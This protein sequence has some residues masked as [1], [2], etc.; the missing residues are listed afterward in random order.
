M[1]TAEETPQ[2]NGLIFKEL[3]KRGY[4]LEG[5][6]R[7]WN[8][9]DSKLWYLTPEQAQGYLDLG[10]DESYKKNMDE[11]EGF[12]LIETN[13]EEILSKINEKH[14]NIID[15]GCGDGKKGATIVKLLQ[16]KAKV[17]YCP[18]DISGY[19]VKK[20]IDLVSKLDVEEIIESQW[21]IS[22]FENLENVTPLLEKGDF[23][24]KIFLILG[25]TIG[26]FEINEIL[27]EIRNSMK[28]G[29][30]LVIDAA[31]NDEKHE[32][33]ALEYTKNKA[34]NNWLI[35]IPEQLGLSKDDV[36]F[37]VRFRAPRLEA[38][39]TIKKDKTISLNKKTVTFNKGDQII[40]LVA[41]KYDKYDLKSFFN[42]YFNDVTVRT[43]KDTCKIL[44]I[45]KK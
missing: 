26:N 34:F 23:K 41:Y 1:T 16:G 8:I 22:D 12:H 30:L 36:E 44:A 21:N 3:I 14:I 5:N 37:G 45:C 32:Q 17:R 11:K 20:A 28:G 7:I 18:I 38:Y 29:D 33:R 2:I 6:T 19:M 25:N 35:K 39:Y 43:S 27:Y 9:A 4:S 13:I 31:I 24:R 15:L 40:I 42:I 10:N